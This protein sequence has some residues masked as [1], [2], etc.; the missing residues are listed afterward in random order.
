[1]T[2]DLKNEGS[3]AFFTQHPH[4]DW[5]TNG[6]NYTFPEFRHMEISIQVKEY[7]DLTMSVDVNGPLG[8]QHHFRAHILPC[9]EQGRVHVS[10]RWKAPTIELFLAGK[11]AKSVTVM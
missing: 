4:A 11:P 5:S 6:H 10:V 8:T 7:S 1:M 9:D 3:V 2:R